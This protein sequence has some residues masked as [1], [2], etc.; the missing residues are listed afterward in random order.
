MAEKKQAKPAPKLTV[1]RKIKVKTIV[2]D[3]FKQ[4][5]LKQL[6]AYVQSETRNLKAIEEQLGKVSKENV[7]YY[8]MESMKQKLSATLDQMPQRRKQ[9]DG[10]KE[11]DFYH[12]GQ[13]EGMASLSVGDQLYNRLY[14]YEIVLKDGVIQE[15]L[16]NPVPSFAPLS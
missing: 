5:L 1:K 6:D 4:D 11:G 10:L 7:I 13:I 12:T 8:E 3:A 9:L 15:I 2:T 14:G 16:T